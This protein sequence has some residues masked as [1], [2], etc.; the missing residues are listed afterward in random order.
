MLSNAISKL[1]K[2]LGDDLKS[3]VKTL[4]TIG[5]RFDAKV[6]R[7]ASGKNFTSNLNYAVGEPVPWREQFVF[8]EQLYAANG[9]EV[10]RI[11]NPKTDETRVVKFATSAAALSSL[12][13]E[14]TLLRL[15]AKA[16][17]DRADF[18]RLH[19]WNFTDSPIYIEGSDAG[20]DLKAW[21]VEGAPIAHMNLSERVAFAQKIAEAVASAHGIGILHKDLKPENIMVHAPDAGP[22]RPRRHRFWQWRRI[23]SFKARC[24]RG[25]TDWHHAGLTS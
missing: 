4:S 11:E 18:A 6:D 8:S 17:P 10:W 20:V 13:R 16:H 25:D 1:R 2:A 19:D 23:R 5:Y 24:P 3:S 7:V 9:K 22:P 21:S 12:K 14:V 15:I